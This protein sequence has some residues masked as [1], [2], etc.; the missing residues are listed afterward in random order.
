MFISSAYND[1]HKILDEHTS[2]N[3]RVNIAQPS[4]TAIFEMQE[5]IN[6]RNKATNYREALTGN[7]EE[8]VLSQ[9]FFSEK[10]IQIIQNGIRAGVYEK[11]N[12]EIIVPPQNID[13]L[14]IIM[15]STY[16]QY[17]QHYPNDITGQVEKLNKLVLDYSINNVY[18][19][20][21]SY[22]KYL[23]DQ[24]TLATPMDRPLQNDR[25]YKQLETKTFM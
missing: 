1:T 2:Y 15:R 18:N 4:E 7:I 6:I 12:Q 25:D 23:E 24:S 16:L 13:N 10:N 22:L 21:L 19:G 17:A 14:K 9:V 11:S 20:A 8:N 3:G 5:K